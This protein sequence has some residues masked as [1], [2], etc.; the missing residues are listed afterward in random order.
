MIPAG[1]KRCPT[2]I[3]EAAGLFGSS[4]LI[5]ISIIGQR[6]NTL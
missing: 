6:V 2:D 1:I 3:N 4:P 5:E